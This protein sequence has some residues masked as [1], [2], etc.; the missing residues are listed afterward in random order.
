MGPFVVKYI[1]SSGAVHVGNE[2]ENDRFKF[3]YKRV[4]HVGELEPTKEEE[5]K[6]SKDPPHGGN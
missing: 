2:G 1:F 6:Q 4:E 3:H 5:I